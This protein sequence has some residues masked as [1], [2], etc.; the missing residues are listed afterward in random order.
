MISNTSQTF[1]IMY[2]YQHQHHRH[3]R[4]TLMYIITLPTHVEC[5]ERYHRL[6]HVIEDHHTT[7]SV[8]DRSIPITTTTTTNTTYYSLIILLRLL[9]THKGSNKDNHTNNS[10]LQSYNHH[11][12]T[13]IATTTTPTN[14]TNNSYQRY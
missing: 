5:I 14:Y 3:H 6:R 12:Q 13:I 2:C 7:I 11:C 1:I 8:Y 9:S 10:E 4:Y